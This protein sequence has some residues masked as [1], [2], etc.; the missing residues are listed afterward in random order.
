MLGFGPLNEGFSVYGVDLDVKA[1]EFEMDDLVSRVQASIP[2]LPSP[3]HH[4]FLHP[5]PYTPPSVLH[6]HFQRTS[7]HPGAALSPPLR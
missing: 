6:A 5:T 2:V 1:L 4:L 3:R 7:V